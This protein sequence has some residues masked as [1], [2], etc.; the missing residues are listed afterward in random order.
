MG[1]RE[2]QP[3][4][5]IDA[6]CVMSPGKENATPAEHVKGER[7]EVQIDTAQQFQDFAIFD[8]VQPFKAGILGNA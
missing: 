4:P 8:R 3:E 7:G 5:G 2:D 6:G 1:G